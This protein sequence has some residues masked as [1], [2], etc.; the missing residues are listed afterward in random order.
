MDKSQVLMLINFMHVKS[1]DTEI[2]WKQAGKTKHMHLLTFSRA[3]ICFN[4]DSS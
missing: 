2:A 3:Q 4:L 1:S